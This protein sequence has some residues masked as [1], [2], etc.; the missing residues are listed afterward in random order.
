MPLADIG[1]KRL[2]VSDDGAGLPDDYA[3]RGS[4]FDGMRADAER[5]GGM[6]IE[7]GGEDG[8]GTT[9]AC[10]VPYQAD[11]RGG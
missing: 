7:E 6:L 5:M 8:S 9:I 11:E 1:A 2:S 3:E 10:M 4:G